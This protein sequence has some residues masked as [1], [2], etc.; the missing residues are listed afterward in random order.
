MEPAERFARQIV[1]LVLAIGLFIVAIAF[2]ESSRE[3]GGFGLLMFALG[4]LIGALGLDLLKSL[5]K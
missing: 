3:R 5:R 1:K 2:S 4:A